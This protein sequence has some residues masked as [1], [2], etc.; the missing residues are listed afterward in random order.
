MLHPL[1]HTKTLPQGAEYNLRARPRAS[2]RA[3]LTSKRATRPLTSAPQRG[4][5]CKQ[6]KHGDL[7]QNP[8]RFPSVQHCPPSA[9]LPYLAATYGGM[10]EEPPHTSAISFIYT[11]IVTSGLKG[12][13]DPSIYSYIQIY[14]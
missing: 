9:L 10:G 13:L 3:E 8:A 4:K 12:R 14:S 2:E 5:T 6:Q 11:G 7:V 1:S